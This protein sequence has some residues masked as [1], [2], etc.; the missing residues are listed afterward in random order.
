MINGVESAL[1]AFGRFNSTRATR[2]R[3]LL[4]LM[5]VWDHLIPLL[6]KIDCLNK[7]VRRMDIGDIGDGRGFEGEP[8]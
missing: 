3:G 8:E 5:R 6:M 2:G 4:E 1:R 7:G